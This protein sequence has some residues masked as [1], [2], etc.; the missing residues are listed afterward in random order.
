MD[1]PLSNLDAKL[2]V[3][4]RGEITKI[5]KNIGATTIYVTHDQTEAMTMADRIVIMKDGWIQQIGT[6]AEV[7]A[8][9]AN[10]FVAGFIGSPAMNFLDVTFKKGVI[11]VNN[12]EEQQDATLFKALNKQEE[13]EIKPAKEIVKLLKDY[14]GKEL[15]LGIRPEYTYLKDD[16]NNTQPSNA[17]SAVA[18]S[19][20]LL[21]KDLIITTYINGQR[22]AFKSDASQTIKAGDEIEF[23]LDMTY[24]Y[25]FDKETEQRI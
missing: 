9:P 14:E 7:Y 5:H 18:D 2:R 16:K 20:E 21:G 15:T 8:N 1:E 24:V 4:T 10:K 25:F 11:S 3:Q 6:P 13:I 12:I 19:V 23:C 17:I 22:V